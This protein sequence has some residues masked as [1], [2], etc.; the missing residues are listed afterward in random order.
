MV[1]TLRLGF[2]SYAHKQLV[3][4]F[5]TLR[6]RGPVPSHLLFTN[7]RISRLFGTNVLSAK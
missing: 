2:D 3:L 7:L 4:E 5:G 1:S 6:F